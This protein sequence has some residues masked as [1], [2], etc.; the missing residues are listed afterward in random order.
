MRPRNRPRG[1]REARNHILICDLVHKLKYKCKNNLY[2]Y[3]DLTIIM[4]K[5][6]GNKAP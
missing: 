4:S 6:A 2:L 3:A 5:G 1:I